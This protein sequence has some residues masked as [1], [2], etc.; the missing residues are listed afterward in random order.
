MTYSVSQMGSTMPM[1]SGDEPPVVA[2]VPLDD[3]RIDDVRIDDVRT[4]EQFVA[5]MRRRKAMSGLTYLELERRADAVGDE[6]S[7]EAVLVGDD[8]MPSERLVAAFARACGDSPDDVA[9]WVAAHRRIT[10]AAP[11]PPARLRPHA[12]GSVPSG[13]LVWAWMTDLLPPVFV[14]PRRPVRMLAVTVAGVLLAAVA[15][16]WVTSAPYEEDGAVPIAV[17][18]DAGDAGDE[19]QAGG[20]IATPD[21]AVRKGSKPSQ[22]KPRATSPT[23][24]PA[25]TPPEDQYPYPPP[26]DGAPGYPDSPPPDEEPPPEEW[27]DDG[28]GGT[29]CEPYPS[30]VCRHG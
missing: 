13:N 29:Y 23:P 10:V 26:D 21:S 6:L 27:P 30:P 24:T 3:V 17:P 20:R 19:P 18:D 15:A 4:P 7:P 16:V 28:G 11:E 14:H 25:E 9:A 12:P 8:G 2:V 22:S 5:A 1:E